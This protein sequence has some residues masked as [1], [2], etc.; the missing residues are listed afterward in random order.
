MFNL[1]LCAAV[2]CQC[3]EYDAVRV[4]NGAQACA[5]LIVRESGAQCASGPGTGRLRASTGFARGADRSVRR[6]RR[7]GGRPIEVSGG[8]LWNRRPR[9]ARSWTLRLATS[10]GSLSLSLSRSMLT[11]LDSP[12]CHVRAYI[13]SILLVAAL[14]QLLTAVCKALCY[15]AMNV[16]IYLGGPQRCTH[17]EVLIELSFISNILASIDEILSAKLGAAAIRLKVAWGRSHGSQKSSRRPSQLRPRPDKDFPPDGSSPLC[18]V[19]SDSPPP[20]RMTALCLPPRL[21]TSQE[22]TPMELLVT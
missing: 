3:V 17:A 19:T 7:E 22:L 13:S 4:M 14:C 2:V 21:P 5:D 16:C 1:G 6:S 11:L 20:P 9:L 12:R 10:L 15:N 8:N 18:D